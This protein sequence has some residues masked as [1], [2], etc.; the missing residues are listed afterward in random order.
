MKTPSLNSQQDRATGALLGA[1]IGDAMGLGPHWYYDLDDQRRDYGDWITGYTD[2]KP[3]RYH[4]GLRAG[5]LSQAGLILKL[6]V[7]SLVARDGYDQADFCRRLDEDFFPKLDG[8]PNH[9]PGGYTSQ[10]IRHA[11]R[12]RVVEKRPSTECAGNADTTECIERALAIAILYANTPAELVK[13]TE[14]NMALTQSDE[15]VLALSIAFCSALGLVVTGQRFDEKISDTLEQMVDDGVLPFYRTTSSKHPSPREEGRTI[16]RS[17]S[18]RPRGNRSPASFVPLMPCS[19]RGGWPGLPT[20]RRS[21]SSRH[22]EFRPSTAC[23]ARFI[24]FCPPFITW[25]P[26]FGETSRVRFS[27]RSTEAATI[28]PAPC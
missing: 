25:P 21:S 19:C 20:I 3:D 5:D 10:S 7:E 13:R 8:R 9:G 12:E 4:G 2:P 11:W 22:R 17:S 27:M 28:K 23:P 26:A 15:T 24:T 16:R 18:S 6:T 1:F 14:S